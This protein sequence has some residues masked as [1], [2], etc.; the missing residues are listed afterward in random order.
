MT[1]FSRVEDLRVSIFILLFCTS[2]A[3]RLATHVSVSFAVRPGNTVHMDITN[4]LE[5]ILIS[6][7]MLMIPDTALRLLQF[8]CEDT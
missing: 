2:E 5:F 3:L 4:P 6:S 1:R 7:R 8:T